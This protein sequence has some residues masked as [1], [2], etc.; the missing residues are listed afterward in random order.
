M[1]LKI[2]ENKNSFRCVI[3]QGTTSIRIFVI[4]HVGKHDDDDDENEEEEE[5]DDA[6]A[7]PSPSTSPS[8]SPSPT[9]TPSPEASPS[10]EVSPSPSASASPS[11][12][13]IEGTTDQ[14]TILQAVI[15]KLNEIIALLNN[16][17]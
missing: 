7:S 9:L 17:L 10:V 2:K 12:S 1:I 4:S 3:R 5:N 16:L 8:T 15:D 6:S 14:A 11:P 13:P